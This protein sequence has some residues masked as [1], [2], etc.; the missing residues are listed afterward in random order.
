MFKTLCYPDVSSLL[1]VNNF[2]CPSDYIIVIHRAFYGKGGN[3]CDY[4]PGDCT[5]EADNVYRLCSG[6]QACS[7]SFLNIF[8][9]PECER[10]I[11]NYLFVEYQC[12]PTLNIASNVNDIC[13][14]QTN[15]LSGVSGIL[16]SRSYPSYTQQQCTNVTLSSPE[17]SNLAIYMYLIDLDIGLPDVQTGKCTDDYLLLSYQCNSQSY[18]EYLCDTRQTELL[19]D[20]CLT[21][22]KIVVSYN[23][24]NQNT[25]SQRGFALLYHLLPRSTITTLSPASIPTT[26]RTSSSTRTTSPWIG[27]GPVSTLISQSTVCAQQSMQLQCNPDYGLVLHKI[28]LAV[29]KTGSCNYSSDDCFE[30]RTYLHGTCGGISSCYI[31]APLIALSK[32]NNSQSNYF[33]AEYQCIPTRPKLNVDVCSPSNPLERVEGGAIVSSMGYTSENKEC[34]VVLQSA[35]VLANPTYTAFTVYIVM[36]NLPIQSTREQGS[37]CNDNDPYIEI[38]DSQIGTTRICGTSHTRQLFETC[39][40]TI[41]IRYRNF[42]VSTNNVRFKGF[43]LYFESI[44]K[45]ECS[46]LVII[47]PPK[48]REP[49]VITEEITCASSIGSDRVSF[50]CTPDHGLVFLQSYEFVTNDSQSCDITQQTCHYL[51]EQ[52]QSLCSGQQLCTYVHS[53]PI[54]PQLNICQGNKGDLLQ[55]FY[56]CIPMKPT[57]TYLKATFCDDTHITANQGFIETPDYPN[58][59]QNGRRQC[60]LRISLPNTPEGKQ[61]SIFLY[62]INLSIR[63]TSTINSTSSIVCYDSITY[64]DGK[65]TRT[66]CGNIDQPVFEYQTNESDLELTLHIDESLPSDTS[67]NWHGA[68]FFFLIGNQSL[69]SPPTTVITPQSSTKPTEEDTTIKDT[70]RN[71]NH[72][73]TIA[74]VVVAVIVV[75]LGLIGIIYYRRRRRASSKAT[76]TPTI[77]YRRKTETV[78]GDISERNEKRSSIPPAAL[79][80]PASST[81]ISPFFMS[82]NIEDEADV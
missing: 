5:S 74:G 67:N 33:Y 48:P 73:P 53:I 61:L 39:S 27:P 26:M 78:H 45:T 56:Q 12:L 13:I 8:N 46:G 28:D 18:D 36:V 29:S 55:F 82:K 15:E 35:K 34:K 81:F 41:E 17:G 43:Q 49:F 40:D 22:D 9:L 68:R 59:Y 72:G 80:G 24:T 20:T 71:P 2:Q 50:S 38:E 65:T 60:S 25:Q 30:E 3:R 37:Q 7:V 32:C 57:V 70:D 77:Q 75:V 69:P 1:G 58:T 4:T 31:F 23:L 47:I 42:N 52:P 44:E 11:A 10:A 19:F 16:K 62:I 14:S 64:R 51:A 66:L 79:R 6:K 54:G 63:D 21:T 76:D